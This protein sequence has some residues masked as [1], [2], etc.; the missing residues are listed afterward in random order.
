MDKNELQ[1]RFDKEFD[2]SAHY[3]PASTGNRTSTFQ[4]KQDFFNKVCADEAFQ[5]HFRKRAAGGEAVEE[6]DIPCAASTSLLWG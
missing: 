2:S 6:G 4:E 3:S 1:I 5:S